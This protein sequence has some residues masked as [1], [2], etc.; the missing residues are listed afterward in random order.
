MMKRFISVLA[1]LAVLA[2]GI[3]AA[4]EEAYPM[5]DFEL[6]DQYGRVWTLADFEGKVVFLNFWTTWCPYCVQEM[7]DIETLYHEYGENTG[8][9]LIFGIDTPDTVDSVDQAGITSFLSENGFTYPCLMDPDFSLG[10]EFGIQ[11]FP[12]TFIIKPDGN[13][14]GYAQGMLDIDNMRRLIGMGME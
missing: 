8:D 12:T 10:N 5:P 3:P 6:V 13:I 1:L 7:P 4:A 2:I 14:L 11:A 9:V